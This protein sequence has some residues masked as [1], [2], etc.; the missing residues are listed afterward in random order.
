MKVKNH[1]WYDT[2]QDRSNSLAKFHDVEVKQTFCCRVPEWEGGGN[3]YEY[4]AGIPIHAKTIITINLV[5]KVASAQ[6]FF[7]KIKNQ[8][9]L[10]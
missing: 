4:T 6:T 5:E 10:S 1:K 3:A 2:Y 9:I 8:K 7:R